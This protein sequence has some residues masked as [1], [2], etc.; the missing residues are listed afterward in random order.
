MWAERQQTV[1]I[2]SWK[3]DAHVLFLWPMAKS[4]LLK[5]LERF[6]RIVFE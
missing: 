4:R 2:G 6:V 5:L 3:R 1:P